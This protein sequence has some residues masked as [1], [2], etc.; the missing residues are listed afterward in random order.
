[1]TPSDRVYC[2]KNNF[3]FTQET[4]PAIYSKNIE[5][6]KDYWVNIRFIRI[7][8]IYDDFT[9]FMSID[10]DS[11][12]TKPLTEKQF[13]EDLNTSW[14]TVSPKR[15]QLSLGSA[16]GFAVD[17]SRKILSNKL[18]KYLGTENFKWCLDQKVLD[19]M[20]ESKEI[21]SMDL[22]YS[23]FKMNDTSY[24]WT[25]KGNRKYKEKFSSIINEYRKKI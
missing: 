9:P 24:I 15:E 13:L 18:S 8:E 4:T 25:G 1:M 5:T 11:V 14:V 23:D 20:L 21:S 12:F 6:K 7:P 19:E 3:T 17:N 16:L 2:E 22:R 10:A